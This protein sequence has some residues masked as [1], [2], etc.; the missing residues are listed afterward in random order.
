MATSYDT[1]QFDVVTCF[2][3]IEHLENPQVGGVA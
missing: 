1:D 2:D 3:V